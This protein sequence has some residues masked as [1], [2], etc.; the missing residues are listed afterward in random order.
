[1]EL[2]YHN[3]HAFLGLIKKRAIIKIPTISY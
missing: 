1:V 3:L 2:Y